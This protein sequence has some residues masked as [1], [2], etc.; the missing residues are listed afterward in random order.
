MKIRIRLA[1]LSDLNKLMGIF[2]TAR[3]FMQSTGNANQWINGYPQRE[4]IM[5]EINSGH[6][7]VCINEQESVAGTFCFIQGPDPT[8]SR[9]DEGDWLDND[10]YWVIHRIA[11]DGSCRGIFEAC[12]NWCEK[13][14]PNLR[15]DTHA[16]N[17]IM[18]NLF[19]EAWFHTLRNN[20][21]SKRNTSYCL[22]K[23]QHLPLL[24]KLS[25]NSF[26]SAN[27]FHNGAAISA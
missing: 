26:L 22:S 7:Y 4:L 23:T 5:H 17:K 9:I 21:C 16:D 2:D 24:I 20:L 12:I 6:C 13:Q 11:S 18:Q 27:N 25:Y 10:P 1:T 19:R 3:R 14:T 8:Y 15:V